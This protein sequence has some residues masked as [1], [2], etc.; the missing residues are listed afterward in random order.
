MSYTGEYY[1]DPSLHSLTC[2][3][4][5]F[6]PSVQGIRTRLLTEDSTKLTKR[7]D[8]TMAILDLLC[9]SPRLWYV[10]GFSDEMTSLKLFKGLVGL[11]ITNL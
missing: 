3:G 8:Q 5:V 2:L 6:L 1:G 4:R 10:L 7:L 11:W 9:Q